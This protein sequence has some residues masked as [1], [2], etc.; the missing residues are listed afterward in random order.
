MT[1]N[2]RRTLVVYSL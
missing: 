1:Q 2:H